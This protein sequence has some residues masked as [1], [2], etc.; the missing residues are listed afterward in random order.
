MGQSSSS[1]K[2]SHFAKLKASEQ[3]AR[4]AT[5]LADLEKALVL[6]DAAIE[7]QPSYYMSYV[8]KGKLL[9]RMEKFEAALAALDEAREYAD[10]S[11]S[12]CHLIHLYKSQALEGVD[13]YEEAAMER[14]RV[15]KHIREEQTETLE[16]RR[17][18]LIRAGASAVDV[19]Y[20]GGAPNHD[21]SEGPR[22]TTAGGE[23]TRKHRYDADGNSLTSDTFS[24]LSGSA[25]Q[26]YIDPL[27]G[28]EVQQRGRRGDTIDDEDRARFQAYSDQCVFAVKRQQNIHN[29]LHGKRGWYVQ[30]AGAKREATLRGDRRAKLDTFDSTRGTKAYK[31]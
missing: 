4:E 29:F 13:E 25:P 6:I 11:G 27:T 1:T 14:A 9:I 16:R 10:E 12:C 2:N 19:R 21:R 5:C 28:Q 23:D 30:S 24:D 8:S 7:M 26:S 3:V 18:T 22:A 31:K 20:S 17:Q 15:P